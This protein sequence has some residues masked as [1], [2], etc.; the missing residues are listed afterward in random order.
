MEEVIFHFF[1]K[2]EVVKK[3]WIVFADRGEGWSPKRRSKICSLHFDRKFYLPAGRKLKK[4][5][6]PTLRQG[7]FPLSVFTARRRVKVF[8]GWLNNIEVFQRM[9]DDLVKIK[10]TFISSS[11]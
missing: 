2:D 11:L 9:F 1:P 3:K 10:K 6:V 7:K 5:A 8:T 4:N